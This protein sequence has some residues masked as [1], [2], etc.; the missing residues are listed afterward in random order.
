MNGNII[1][2]DLKG[3]GRSHNVTFFILW[4]NNQNFYKFGEKDFVI[5]KQTFTI[6]LS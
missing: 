3:S 1:K 2:F 5:L 6:S 4:E